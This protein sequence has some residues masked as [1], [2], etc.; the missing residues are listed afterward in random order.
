MPTNSAKRNKELNW[1]LAFQE[2]YSECPHSGLEQPEPPAPDI[3]FP[4]SGL[5]IEI[6]EYS[7]GQGKTGS[8][9]RQ[10]ENVHQ[11]IARAAQTAFEINCNYRLQVTILWTNFNECPVLQ[12]EKNIIQA[13]VRL[14]VTNTTTRQGKRF[15]DWGPSNDPL[16]QKYGVEVNIYPIDGAGQSCW[17]SNAC[18]C[19]P[20]EAGRIQTALDEKESKVSGYRQFCQNLWLLIIADGTFFS[21]Q[22]S[23]D[24]NLSQTIFQSSFD[25]IFLLD[26]TRNAIYEFKA[27]QKP[28]AVA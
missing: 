27:E 20:P 26:V 8:R 24:P 23:P 6:T 3:I 17:S 2:R 22:F 15:I 1:L 13:I 5:G 9:P 28:Q 11:R 21:S 19:F 14:V 10:F 16:L 12:E 18:F 4:E 7:M 25:R